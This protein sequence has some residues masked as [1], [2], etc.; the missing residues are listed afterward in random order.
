MISPDLSVDIAYFCE[1]NGRRSGEE[2]E[3]YELEDC[4]RLQETLVY[5]TT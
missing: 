5:R 1:W 2:K 3:K 4:W